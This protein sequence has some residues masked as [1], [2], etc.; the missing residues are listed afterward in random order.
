MP[1]LRIA[2]GKEFDERLIAARYREFICE[3]LSAGLRSKQPA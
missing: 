2:M 1:V 3:L